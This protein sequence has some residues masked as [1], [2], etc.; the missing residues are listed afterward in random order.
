[1]HFFR[2]AGVIQNT[3]DIGAPVPE[4]G[5]QETYIRHF[6]QP[7]TDPVFDIV[8]LGVVAEACLGEVHRTDAAE[9]MLIDLIGGIEHFQ[10]VGRFSR[11]I[12]DGMSKNDVIVFSVIIILDHPGIEFVQQ[13]FVL[14]PAAL[15]LQQEFLSP[16]LLFGFCRE[17]HDQEIS[18]DGAGKRFPYQIKVF[19]HFFFR[20]GQKG[21]IQPGFYR[22]VCI[23]IT[24]ADPCDR[25]PVR[26]ELLLYF[27]YLF[28]VH[29]FLSKVL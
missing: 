22:F 10:P 12:I 24:T 28:F 19:I 2:S 16:A 1:M 25:T 7:V 20:Q 23:Y 29:R 17:V 5:E 27:S 13:F 11:D 26:G 6:H 9:K 21:L 3:V 4:Q 14:Q 15:Q 8:G 18:A